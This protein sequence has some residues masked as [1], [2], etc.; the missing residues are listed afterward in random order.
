MK[1]LEVLLSNGENEFWYIPLNETLEKALKGIE[2]ETG[3]NVIDYEL[4]KGW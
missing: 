2:K 1:H 4:V 3:F